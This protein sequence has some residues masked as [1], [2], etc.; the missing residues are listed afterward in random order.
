MNLNSSCKIPSTVMAR[1]IGTE[2]VILNLASGTYFGLDPVGA[3]IWQLMEQ[4]KNLAQICDAMLE[5]YHVA[6]DVLERDTLALARELAD[7]KLIQVA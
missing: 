1:T 3:R 7:K 6:R 4:G 2:T 5:E